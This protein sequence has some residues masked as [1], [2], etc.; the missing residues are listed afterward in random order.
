MIDSA[1]VLVGKWTPVAGTTYQLRLLAGQQ[2]PLKLYVDPNPANGLQQQL[3]PV[4]NYVGVCSP[5]TTY[6]FLDMWEAPSSNADLSL[7]AGPAPVR[8]CSD[9]AYRKITPAKNG[10]ARQSFAPGNT[11]L[12]N[13]EEGASAFIPGTRGFGYPTYPGVWYVSGS[14]TAGYTVYLNLADGSN[15][16]SHVIEATH[17][18]YG[19]FIEGTNYVTVQ[20]LTV[21]HSFESCAQDI[22]YSDTDPVGS[23]ITFQRLRVFNCTSLGNDYLTQQNTNLGLAHTRGGISVHASGAKNPPNLKSPAVLSSF[24]GTLDSY[25]ASDNTYLAGINLNGIDGGKENSCLA[26]GNFV[27]TSTAPG[28]V[29]NT[30]LNFNA[31]SLPQNVG[32]R[33]A[34]NELTNNQLGIGFTA[35]SGG[36]LDHNY[37]HDSY[38][39]G[40]QI[41][42][43]SSSTD[44][45]PGGPVPGSQVI[46]NNLIVNLGRSASR[47]LYNGID[48]NTNSTL[49]SGFYE[50]HNT[51]VNTWGAGATFEGNGRNGCTA[52]HFWRNVIDQN[53]PAFGNQAAL[54]NWNPSMR[55]LN[56]GNLLYIVSGNHAGYDFHDNFYRG[57]PTQ[58]VITRASAGSFNCED[59][60]TNGP[61]RN[62][63]C[64]G[65]DPMFLNPAAND[66]RIQTKSPLRSN[67]RNPRDIGAIPYQSPE[68]P[69]DKNLIVGPIK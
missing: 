28:I 4:P 61:D 67:Q 3:L 43:Y 14:P 7:L 27:N 25:F 60:I 32:G 16:N 59:W 26:C 15:P 63:T 12:Q 58:K 52:P 8:G 1:D 36:L 11:G 9:P 2:F 37:I 41:G 23:Y 31:G 44:G 19:V 62:S 5:G 21:A 46:S 18:I 64:D 50:M 29:Y 6:N 57:A 68:L 47:S 20:D 24:V 42:G 53:Y 45:G 13:V 51:I 49:F 66:F 40:I 38:G 48:C 55:S 35:I 39:E 22:P 56:G 17:R 33:I 30:S 10:E 54:P 65:T 69:L 34:N